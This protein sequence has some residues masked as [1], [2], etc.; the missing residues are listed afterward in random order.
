MFASTVI[1]HAPRADAQT[2]PYLDAGL[3]LGPLPWLVD[4]QT[5]DVLGTAVQVSANGNAST[6]VAS[7]RGITVTAGEVLDRVR[8]ANELEQRRYAADPQALEALVD[9]I[10]ADRLLAAEARRR[11]LESDPAVRAVVE[12]AL[13]ARLRATA[14]NTAADAQRVTDQ[15]ARAFYD[16]NAYRFHIPERRRVAVLFTSDLP[17]LQREIRRWGR[18]SRADLRRAFR[19]VSHRLTT[20]E[21]LVRAEYEMHDVTEAREDMDE[22]LRRATFALRD[23]GDVSPEPV[24]G[25]FRGRRGYWMVRLMDKR[26]AVD[27]TFEESADWIRGRIASERRLQV[28]RDLVQRLSEQAA[29]RRTPAA[30]VVRVQLVPDAGNID[31]GL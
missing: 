21:E 28:E 18:L 15:E 24:A 31:A 26:T 9:R 1:G 25:S 30:S 16:G 14:L 7:G 11:G 23:E 5:P 29:V 3:Q 12:R 17:R 19:E 13:I 27:R 2:R 6:A 22:A 10:V 4:A 20:D 8:D